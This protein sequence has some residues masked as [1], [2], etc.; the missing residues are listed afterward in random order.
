MNICR[1]VI[2]MQ[3]FTE[4]LST[5]NL[6]NLLD[7]TIRKIP[8]LDVTQ[9]ELTSVTENEANII[10]GINI[11]KTIKGRVNCTAQTLQLAIKD[12]IDS[13]ATINNIITK[14]KVVNPDDP[15]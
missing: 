2:A 4:E 1:Y 13:D 9:T 12:C 8:G 10:R 5:E 14:L 11:S 3:N 6:A 15:K 7:K